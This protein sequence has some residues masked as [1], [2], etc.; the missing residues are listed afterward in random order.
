MTNFDIYVINLDKDTERLS[1][2]TKMIYPNQFT[3]I[4]AIYGKNIDIMN[5]PYIFWLSKYLTPYSV[6]GSGLSHKLTINTFLNNSKKDIALI[7]E[8]DAE[9]ITSNYITE[10][11]HAIKNAPVDWDIIKLDYFPTITNKSLL[12]T[13]YLIN[14]KGA[15]KCKNIKTIYYV[16]FDFNF[17]NVNI[18]K[19]SKIIFQQVWDNS[20][21][22][23]NMIMI[24]S[25]PL[26]YIFIY[27][28]FKFKLLRLGNI[29]L[30]FNDIL[31][32]III[33]VIIRIYKNKIFTII[34]LR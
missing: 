10:I 27:P 2:F 20:N 29:E 31:F 1:K 8:D 28:G 13:A 26:N 16:D 33:I 15:N 17:Y 30:S 23:S 5:N 14:K 18:Y 22:S 6:I 24:Q 3:R 19:S 34:K 21:N 32:I 12:M 7:F 9:P 25:N 11:Q 4:P